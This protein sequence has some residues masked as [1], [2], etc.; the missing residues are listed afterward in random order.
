MATDA[1]GNVVFAW[2]RQGPTT[3]G[4]D[5]Y[6]RQFEDD[7]LVP[8]VLSRL[9]FYNQSIFDGENAAANAADDA[10]IATNKQAL[11]PGQTASFANYSSYNRGINGM[12]IDVLGL[13]GTP[14][15][16]DFTFKVGNVN[17]PTTWSNGP[18]PTSVSVR[19]GAGVD[20]SDRITLLWPDGAIRNQWLQVIL[21]PNQRT[22][23]TSPDVFYFGSAVGESGNETD[24]ANVSITD[25]LLARNNATTGGANTPVTSRFDFN[26][27]GRISVIDQ[28]LARNNLTTTATAVKLVVPPQ[29][30]PLM[31]D[32]PA[33]RD[34]D[35][36]PTV[37]TN[38]GQ[39]ISP[40]LRWLGAP[41]GTQEFALIVDDPDASTTFVHWVIYK[42]PATLDSLQQNILKIPELTSPNGVLQGQG[43]S[44]GIGYRGPSP[45]AG[46]V[47][48]YHFKLYALDAKLAVA[49]GLT[50]AQL[51]TAMQGHI[52]AMD[53]FI[54]TYQR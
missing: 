17:D 20:G 50:K 8:D 38:D 26:R 22:G 28:L 5:I 33:F 29:Q 21:W 9:V 37:Y 16:G 51:L 34:G 24:N 49:S 15:A 36:I 2:D 23:L 7:E 18:T 39:N 40:P 14:T 11:L 54:G 19:P 46:P 27:D 45:P 47:H 44:G 52:L 31:L 6:A 3:D 12:M 53:D 1:T 43:S 48:H 4:T 42:I 35:R 30:L 25:E 10:A 13:P 41:Q 32:S